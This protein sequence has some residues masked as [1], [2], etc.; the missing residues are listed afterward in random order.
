MQKAYDFARYTLDLTRG[1]LN[2]GDHVIELRPKSF[3]LL[4]YLVENAE[5]ARAKR[6]TSRR[7]SARCHGWRQIP[8]KCISEVRAALNDSAQRL[9]K[10]PGTEAQLVCS[11]VPVS[12]C[13]PAWPRPEP[14]EPRA[15]GETGAL[16]HP[17]PL[18]M[19]G[20]HRVAILSWCSV[21]V[22]FG[23]LA[24]AFSAWHRPADR[25][26]TG[27]AIAV[28]PFVNSAGQSRGRTTSVTG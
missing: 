4:A 20:C 19:P 18:G 3:R 6:R 17:E 15:D 7:Q 24:A 9:V 16:T 14:A 26:T 13:L 28:L 2:A 8:A 11:D 22:V 12:P 25:P 23:I 21:D 10:E 27:P 5:P 1:S